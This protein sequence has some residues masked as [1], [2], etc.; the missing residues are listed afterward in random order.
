MTFQELV[1]QVQALSAEELSQLADLVQSLQKQPVKPQIKERIPGLS[2][3]PD[4]WMSDDF[5][6]PLPD[7]RRSTVYRYGE[8]TPAP[9]D[10][11]RL[12]RKVI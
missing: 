1:Q 12:F 4:F 3:H 9:P 6:D 8:A 10:R 5:D 7:C 11:A 2:A